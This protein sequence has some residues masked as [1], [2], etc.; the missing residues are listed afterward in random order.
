MRTTLIVGGA[1]LVVAGAA[2]VVGVVGT[3]DGADPGAASG[4]PAAATAAVRRGNLVETTSASGSLG[5]G[6]QRE[7]GTSL[8]GTLTWL[9][10]AGSV[11]GEGDRLYE[12]DRTPVVRLDGKVPAWRDLGPDIPDGVDVKQLERALTALGYPSDYDLEV[13]GEW[14]WATT[15]AVEEWQEDRGL[16]ET[17][18]L[19][20]GTVVFTDG[21][22]RIGSTLAGIG[23]RVQP[24]TPLLDVTADRRH[25]VVE[26]EP[27]RRNLAPI[28]ARVDLQFPD[29]T[30]AA[31]RVTEVDVVPPADEQS[32][33]TLA[34]T[35]EPTGR[36]SERAFS[37]Q[38]DGASVLVSFSDVLARDVLIVPVTAL[39][40][41]ADGGYAVEVAGDTGARVVEV[42]TEG[43]ADSSVAISGDLGEGDQ[44]VVTP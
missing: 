8:P 7:I 24:G 10:R 27:S 26:L 34:V 11:V 3:S 22:L 36:W 41:L 19:P 44:V 9:P 30:T 5:Y 14:T 29:G 2:A 12:V 1:V 28:G 38:L 4:D 40:A 42:S 35:V 43:F 13:D 25:V 18:E 6:D 16:E 39:L 15:D 17:G 32:D 31:G 20:L 33:E 37:E 21:D 23:D